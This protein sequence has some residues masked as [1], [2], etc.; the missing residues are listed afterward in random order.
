M[1]LFGVHILKVCWNFGV[2]T[3]KA[4]ACD[5]Q[6]DKSILETK[7]HPCSQKT[8]EN[9]IMHDWYFSRKQQA[10]VSGLENYDNL[11]TRQKGKTQCF[12]YL[13]YKDRI[14]Q[15]SI[16]QLSRAL[17]RYLTAGTILESI[18]HS[19]LPCWSRSG[20]CMPRASKPSFN[21]TLVQEDLK[22]LPVMNLGNIKGNIYPQIVLS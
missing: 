2:I 15:L 21:I 7:V 20:S 17:T 8:T 12:W 14:M 9:E 13:I 19:R 6:S 4:I 16:L 1:T 3:L 18:Q 10:I 5:N 11:S 22:F